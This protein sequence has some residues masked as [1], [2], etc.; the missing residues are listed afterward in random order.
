M[1]S[2]NKYTLGIILFFLFI[3]LISAAIYDIPNIKI[4]P[5]TT[6]ILYASTVIAWAIDAFLVKK[7][8][9]EDSKT[10]YS[11]LSFVCFI[12]YV[13]NILSS[14]KNNSEHQ[15]QYAS[16][17]ILSSVFMITLWSTNYVISDRYPGTI[18][19]MICFGISIIS[20]IIIITDTQ[21]FDWLTN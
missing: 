14:I 21:V 7:L 1:I 20:V 17:Y 9:K 4:K 10:L 15:S 11:D 2:N 3:G 6:V 16:F 5:P 8:Y 12:S 18:S 13:S 19:R